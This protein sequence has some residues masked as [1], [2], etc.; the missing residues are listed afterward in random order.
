MKIGHGVAA[1]G[2]VLGASLGTLA[3]RAEEQPVPA[4]VNPYA[5]LQEREEKFE[6]AQKPA[7]K[8]EGEKWVVTFA[9]TANCDA[10][11]SI[12]NKDGKI[13][14]HLASGVLGKNAPHP[15]RQNSLAQK[16]EWDGLT[17][18]FKKADT[19]GCK[20]KVG[21][22]LKATYERDIGWD[23]QKESY[24]EKDGKYFRTLMPPPADTPEDKLKEAG[25]RPI[26]TTWGER[27]F[28]GNRDGSFQA[29]NG[30]CKPPANAVPVLT[31][32]F[33]DKAP[34]R[35]VE[36]PAVPVPKVDSSQGGLGWYAFNPRLAV[37]PDTDDLYIGSHNV[38]YRYDGKTGKLDESWFPKGDLTFVSE[39][40]VGPDGL[41]YMRVSKSGYGRWLI[42]TDR[43]GKPVD[44][45]K[46]EIIPPGDR[47]V[48]N[49][50]N[51]EKLKG[52]FTGVSPWCQMHQKGFHVSPSGRIVSF[53][54]EMDSKWVFEK[55]LAKTLPPPNSLGCFNPFVAVWD[56]DGQPLSLN[57]VPGAGM[58][59][60]IHMDREGSIYLAQA[61]FLL[62]D[63]KTLFGISEATM[64]AVGGEWGL[65]GC[66]GALIKFRGQGEKF[67]IGQIY[68]G[69]ALLSASADAIKF[70]HYQQT[71]QPPIAAAT[72][73]LW[74]YGGVYNQGR[75]G[76]SCNHSRDGMDR[77]GRSWISE[78]PSS[79]VVAL[80]T[81]GNR[82]IRIGKYG[83]VDDEGIRFAWVRALA[84]SDNALY[85]MDYASRRVLK[86]ALSY[87]AEETLP[88]P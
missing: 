86:A 76:C 7:V 74:A 43:S 36:F 57:A 4:P 66:P 2:W 81:N 1:L 82:I 10:T 83:N 67:P 30:D 20:V 5:G 9:T 59:H 31:P 19:A 23:P 85:A 27:T 78:N 49:A 58:G 68:S 72:G 22:G 70:R 35:K 65:W 75:G 29:P 41:I 46:G 79:T 84:A 47:E 28:L 88:L 52:V 26:T 63:Q 60:G 56:L 64:K 15:F 55:G 73:A 12:L 8:K 62:A 77:W 11:V 54:S 44:F 33:K 48:P 25:L 24:L 42:R 3:C 37:A 6:F 16:L 45:P 13:V 38:I 32:V 80:D 53:L 50:L 21:L 18:D 40:D 87:T 71:T 34:P 17:D 51:K 14:R 69:K 61:Y 39:I